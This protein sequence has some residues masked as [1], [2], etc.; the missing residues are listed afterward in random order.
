MAEAEPIFGRYPCPPDKKKP[1]H[2]RGELIKHFIYP[3]ERPHFSD[4]NYLFVS[5]DKLTVGTWQLTP[6]AT[7]DPPDRHPGDEVYYVLEGTLT[8]H[9]PALGEFM[10]VNAGEAILLPKFGYHKGY[11]FE[12]RTMR[13]L[14][15]I[16]PEIWEEG[17]PPMSFQPDTMKRYKGANNANL[18]TNDQMPEWNNH[19]T[20]DDIGRWPVPGPEARTEPILFYHIPENKKLVNIHGTTYPMLVKF[21]V[22]N[23]LLH[24]GE[25]I[26][27]TGGT[28]CR[29]SEPDSHAGDAAIFVQVGPI[30]FFLPD[31]K[32][33]FDVQEEEVMYIP[34]G[35][36]YQIINNTDHGIKA[37]F[38]I[39]PGI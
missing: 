13:I 11:N 29:A 4:L 5:S 14:Y 26:L 18:P 39:A 16:A 6:G 27:P 31:T 35:V 12:N 7:Y 3:D 8:E 25:F 30:T 24:M 2:V 23:D 22:S 28:G 17:G 34:E 33:A 9:N 38:S 10:Q 19:G 20:T 37:I 32:E 1:V 36:R 21:F 15:V